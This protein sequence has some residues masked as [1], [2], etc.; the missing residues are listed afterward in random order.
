M[1]GDN[2]KH[3]LQAL[4]DKHEV[5][6]RYVCDWFHIDRTTAW[7]MIKAGKCDRTLLWGL[8]ALDRY[9]TKNGTGYIRPDK[10]V[11]P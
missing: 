6:L 10:R 8:H 5:P 3:P 1:P 7:R 11:E 9:W 2:R 4:A